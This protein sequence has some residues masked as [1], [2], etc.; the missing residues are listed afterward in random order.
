M[1]EDSQKSLT[2]RKSKSRTNGS[3]VRSTTNIYRLGVYT[4]FFRGKDGGKIQKR[5]KDGVK[6]K[7][8]RK[9]GGKERTLGPKTTLQR[10]ETPITVGRE[11]LM[12]TP[13]P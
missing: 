12:G 13:H 2:R 1:N 5:R 8:G 10:P 3:I 4:D 6:A 9:G 11:S 7:R